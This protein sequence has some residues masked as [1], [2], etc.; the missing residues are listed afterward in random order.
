V[1]PPPITLE[2]ANQHIT[3][4]N[5]DLLGELATKTLPDG[6]LTENRQYDTNGNLVSLTHFNGVTT[7]YSYDALNRLLSRITPGEPTLSFT[8][9][10]TG[11][12]QTMTDAGGTTSYSY[13][14]MDRL[15][16]RATPEG[17]LSYAYDAAGNPASIASNHVH[18]VST[19]YAYD[20]RNRLSTVEDANLPSGANTTSYSYDAAS[21]VGQ[22]LYPNGVQSTMTYDVLNRIAGLATQASSYS[23]QRGAVGNL[24][25]AV[26]SSGRTVQ[27]SYD[28]INRL[29]GENIAGAAG[30]ANGSAS[31]SLDPVGNRLSDSSS[32]PDVPS[33]SYGYNADDE[34]NTETYDLN[35]NTLTTGGKAFSYDSENHLTSMNGGA[36]T[37]IYDGD[38]NRVGKSVASNGTTVTT[39]YLV[40]DLNPTGYPQVVE[41]LS[42]AG[43]VAHQYTYGLQRISENQVLNGAWTP[44]F[45]GYDG[46]GNV[47]QLT[48]SAGAVTDTYEYDAFGNKINSTGTTPN[49]YLYRGEQYDPDLGLYYLRARYYNPLT[50]RFLSRDP[51]D[52]TPYDPKTLHKYLYAGGDPVNA[53]DPTGRE[54]AEEYGFLYTEIRTG[55]TAYEYGFALGVAAKYFCYGDAIYA[56]VHWALTSESASPLE[57]V[58]LAITVGNGP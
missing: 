21:N 6:T 11:K 36:V 30:N 56:L 51:E 48:S 25:N 20:S 27:W 40:D 43:V 38:G 14:S 52:G 16:A 19:T 26:E 7:T 58:C 5:F 45:Y 24:T 13:D 54:D 31:Y 18:G 1:I 32:I 10:A 2:D 42:G 47:R 9:T 28:G 29:T 33:G 12:R 49:N 39:Y 23:Y 22:V 41:E 55:L 8:Y 17:T 50:G 46:G 3:A 35:G 44:S 15:T 57:I 37:L 53:K 4:S 34:V